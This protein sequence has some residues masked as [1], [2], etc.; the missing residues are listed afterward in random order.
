MPGVDG[1][2]PPVQ[3]SPLW[4]FL[5]FGLLLLVVL[6]FV[7]VPVFTKAK[8]LPFLPTPPRPG[9]PVPARTRY[10]HL[11]DEIEHAYALQQLTVRE[12]HQRLSSVVRAYA[13]ES[14]GYPASAMT[15]SELRQLDLPR[16]SSAIERFYPAEFGAAAHGS[17]ADAVM[18]ARRVVLE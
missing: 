11:I 16:L 18:D 8:P 10:A 2:Y 17:V 9:P 1:F 13:H 7:L 4:A 3:F 14:S 12:A 6:W 15:L 5:G